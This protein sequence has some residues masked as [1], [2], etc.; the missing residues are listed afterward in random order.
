MGGSNTPKKP[1]HWFGGAFF[2]VVI[3]LYGH[4]TVITFTFCYRQLLLPVPSNKIFVRTPLQI[5]FGFAVA[6]AFGF[7][8]T[9]ATTW[10]SAE[11]PEPVSKTWRLNVSVE[12]MLQ[13]VDGRFTFPIT[14]PP[15]LVQVYCMPGELANP[16]SVTVEQPQTGVI[17]ETLASGIGFTVRI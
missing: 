3:V 12:Q 9:T 2:I 16:S 6:V 17:G 8:S 1:R 13:V 15:K 10:E 14:L 5:R 4:I 11:Q 7:G